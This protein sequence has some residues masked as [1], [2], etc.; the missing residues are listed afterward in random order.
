[1]SCKLT[2]KGG[3]VVRMSTPQ[4]RDTALRS[5]RI[6][7]HDDRPSAPAVRDTHLRATPISRLDLAGHRVRHCIQ[8][9][10]SLYTGHAM[11]AAAP[12]ALVP[13]CARVAR[14]V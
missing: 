11:G 8:P 3:R 2:G 10:M 14:L 12:A 7:R 5:L 13:L 4:G 9:G 6:A 1:M